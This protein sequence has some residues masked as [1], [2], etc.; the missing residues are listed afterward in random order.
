MIAALAGLLALSA[1]AAA[2]NTGSAGPHLLVVKLVEKGGSTPYA[3]EPASVV[4]Q[5]GDTLRFVEAT[6]A[7]HN[8][9]F[10]KQ[11]AG[12]K[13]GAATSGPYF[14]AKGQTYDLIID[15]RFAGGTYE[16][17]CDPHA[18]IGMKGTLSVKRAVGINGSN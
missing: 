5:L 3:F 8:V 1:P 4:A 15:R 11:P 18:A 13:L 2:Q 17:V 10:T 9:R 12:A 6:G 16:F 14:T 7:I